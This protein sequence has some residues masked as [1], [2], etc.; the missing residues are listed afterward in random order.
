MSFEPGSFVTDLLLASTNK[1][2]R[3][4]ERSSPAARPGL[5]KRRKKTW[6]HGNIIEIKYIYL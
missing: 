3:E 2:Q 1:R 5:G 6:L 4:R